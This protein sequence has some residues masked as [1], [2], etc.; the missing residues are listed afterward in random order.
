MYS[1]VALRAEIVEARGE[2]Y[3]SQGLRVRAYEKNNN[4]TGQLYVGEKEKERIF[5]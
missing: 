4:H 1:S 5:M 3:N 2:F